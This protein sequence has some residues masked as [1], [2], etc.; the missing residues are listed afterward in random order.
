ML[1]FSC[2]HSVTK[3]TFF[4]FLEKAKVIEDGRLKYDQMP[5]PNL[6]YSSIC[7]INL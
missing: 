7:T 1:P 6:Q 4:F 2:T 3:R 5:Y